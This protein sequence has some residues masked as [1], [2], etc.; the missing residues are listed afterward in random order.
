MSEGKVRL[1]VD[2]SAEE[3]KRIKMLATFEDKTISEY[4]L[5][6]ARSR[7]AALSQLGSSSKKDQNESK[8][9]ANDGDSFWQLLGS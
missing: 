7:M 8:I 3:R 4:L 2:C 6:L 1:S 9:S 5:S